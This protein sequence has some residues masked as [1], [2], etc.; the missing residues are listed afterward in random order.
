[1]SSKSMKALAVPLLILCT[2]C[3]FLVPLPA[4]F[5]DSLIVVNCVLALVLLATVLYI[6]EPL[7]LSALP[8]ILLVAAL[9]RIGLNIST[10]RMILVGGNEM[11]AI[12]ES[13]GAI[14]LQGSVVVGMTVFLIIT[15]VQF[16]VISK[17][18][19]RVAEV[20]ARFV[21]DA[22]PGRQMSIDADAR[23]GVISVAQAMERR[24]RLQTESRF[25]A[26]LDGSMKF[27]KGDAIAGLGIT[28]INLVGGFGIGVGLHGMGAGEAAATYSLLTVGDGLVSQVPSLL[29]SIAAGM[30]ITKVSHS[31]NTLANDLIAQLAG[32]PP[33]RIGVGIVFGLLPL[34]FPLPIVPFLAPGLFLILTALYPGRSH[35]TVQGAASDT[36]V[37]LQPVTSSIHLKVPSER[38]LTGKVDFDYSLQQVALRFREHTGLCLERIE[39]EGQESDRSCYLTLRGA[40]IGS[41]LLDEI[42]STEGEFQKAFLEQWLFDTLDSVSAELMDDRATR[43]IMAFH[44]EQGFQVA[45]DIV[46]GSVSITR[47]TTILRALLRAKISVINFDLIMQAVAESAQA[48]LDELAML[49]EVRLMLRRQISEMYEKNGSI[50]CTTLDVEFEQLLLAELSEGG[51]IQSFNSRSVLSLAQPQSVIVCVGVL[52]EALD[53]YFASNR[54]DIRVVSYEELLPSVM[55]RSERVLSPRNADESLRAKEIVDRSDVMIGSKEFAC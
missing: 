23:A 36:G 6:E 49:G 10:T 15:L 2:L 45:A 25:Y 9:F 54:M 12:V 51:I 47:V 43:R 46:P 13:A 53:R 7:E 20:S 55:L 34:F 19:E 14:A 41:V 40:S 24:E 31:G 35:S 17:G 30:L 42:Y 3:G 18:A 11:S 28:A 39:L 52:R 29:N 22:L 33:V 38:L 16:V 1:M 8:G 44:A 50:A 4:T 21:L 48:G 32:K 5:L 27:V 37:S 26:A